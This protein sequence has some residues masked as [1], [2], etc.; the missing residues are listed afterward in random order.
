MT[1]DRP[2]EERAFLSQARCR[3]LIAGAVRGHLAIFMTVPP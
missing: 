3:A 2:G 1:T